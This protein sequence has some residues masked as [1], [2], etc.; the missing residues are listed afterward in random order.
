MLGTSAYA[1][2]EG[3]VRDIPIGAGRAEVY[4][5]LGEGEYKSEYKETYK[6]SNGRIAVLSYLN[7]V[8]NNGYILIR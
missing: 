1:L 4:A 3:T 8:L 7:D 5:M 2:D 6:L